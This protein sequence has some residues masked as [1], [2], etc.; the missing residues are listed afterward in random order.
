MPFFKRSSSGKEKQKSQDQLSS[1]LTENLERI[2]QKTGNSSDITIRPL[3][4]SGTPNMNGALIF[5]GGLVEEQSINDFIIESILHRNFSDDLTPKQVYTVISE[6]VISL[7]SIKSSN[8]SNVLFTSLMSG[9]SIIL[10]DG[11]AE[12]LIVSTRGGER[13]SIQ[14]PSSQVVIRGPHEGFTESISTNIAM[15]RRIIKSPDLWVETMKIGRVT[16]TDVSIMYLNGIAKNEVVDEVRN[17]LQGIKIDSI[18]ESGYIEQLI[19][20]QSMT[21]FPTMYHTE[22]PD[23]V[24]GNLLEGR[25]AI[26]VDGTPFVLVAPVVFMQ[27]FQTMEDYYTRKEG[28]YVFTIQ[29]INPGNVASGLQG[30]SGGQ[31]PPTTAVSATGDTIFSSFAGSMV[32][33]SMIYP[34]VN[35]PN[36]VKMT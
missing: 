20:D 30:G 22:R 25:V 10:I 3:K 16:K 18:L 19:E 5:V 34:Y 6:Q 12:T 32:V 17:R 24:A 9:N 7:S 26:F 8:E 15:V 11:V 36:K 27:F 31:A 23:S 13:R 35:H 2:K 1:S 4:I 33:F 29:M 28:K 21:T 14:E